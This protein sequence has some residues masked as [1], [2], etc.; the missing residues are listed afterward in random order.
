MNWIWRLVNYE[1]VQR[2][3][4]MLNLDVASTAGD[5]R[6]YKASM[7]SGVTQERRLHHSLYN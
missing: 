5:E 7:A 4:V 2:I 1:S 6:V 3:A